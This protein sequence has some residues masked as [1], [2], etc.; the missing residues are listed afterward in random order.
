MKTALENKGIAT[1]APVKEIVDSIDKIAMRG[2]F[3]YDLFRT[4]SLRK[5]VPRELKDGKITWV[6]ED[7]NSDPLFVFRVPIAGYEQVDESIISKLH[8]L[9][10]KINK[11]PVLVSGELTE[12]NLEKAKIYEYFGEKFKVSTEDVYQISWE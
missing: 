6:V 2:K 12:E 9:G 10:Y 1:F 7:Q 8:S 4:Y 11:L 3:Q 5:K